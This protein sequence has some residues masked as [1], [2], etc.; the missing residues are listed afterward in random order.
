[1]KPTTKLS[2]TSTYYRKH[3]CKRPSEASTPKP[4]SLAPLV[5]HNSKPHIRFPHGH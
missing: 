1:V 3:K 2:L 4:K 5:S